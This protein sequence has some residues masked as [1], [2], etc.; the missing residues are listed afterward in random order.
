MSLRVESSEK[1]QARD[2]CPCPGSSLSLAVGEEISV[3]ESQAR[4]FQQVFVSVRPVF[5]YLRKSHVAWIPAQREALIASL[6]WASD[7]DENH[8]EP[9][10]PVGRA[11]FMAVRPLFLGGHDVHLQTLASH[12]LD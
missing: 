1:I 11:V 4:S 5:P 9:F 6:H 10:C 3:L 2:V 12:A 7:L 8:V